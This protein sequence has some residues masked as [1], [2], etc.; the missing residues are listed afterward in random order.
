MRL[1]LFYHSLISDWNHGNA[2]F[3]R[4]VVAELLD[5]AHHVVVYEPADG[6]SRQHLLAEAG[7]A[8]IER[9]HRAFP[10][11]AAAVVEYDR[12]DVDA[13]LEGADLV[14][15]HEWNPHWLVAAIGRH[16]AHGG[17]YRLLF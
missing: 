2:H 15:V 17:R 13:A 3:L 1:V 11:L 5:R 8:A 16:R 4:G 14:I 10:D 12:L 9:F 6:W 7:A